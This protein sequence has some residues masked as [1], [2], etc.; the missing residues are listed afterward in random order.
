[1]SE[2]IVEMSGRM[3]K[4]V[5]AFKNDLSRVRTGRASISI[6][7]DITVV[8]Y[9]STMP[10]N[11]VATLTIPESRMIALQPWDPQMIPPIEKAILKSGLGLN[12][13]NDGKVVRL[14]IPQLTEDRRKDLVK[15]VKKIAEEFRVAIRN[16]RRDAIDTLKLQKKDKE[17]SEDDLFKLQDD[18]QKETDIYIKQ[19]DE[20]SA[21]KEKEVME[22]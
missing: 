3:A 2:V 15:Q 5:E 6:L 19:L 22:V 7:D 21:S 16:V 1:M 18:A 12:P 9:G 11:Q 13:V 8:A 14:N 17:I 20:V 4:S 10:L